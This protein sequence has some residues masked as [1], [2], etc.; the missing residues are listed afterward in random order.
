MHKKLLLHVCCGPCTIVVI[1]ML[2]EMNFEL[3]GIFFNPNIHPLKE[4]LKRRESMNMLAEQANLPMIWVDDQ[5]DLTKWLAMVADNPQYG[6][7]CKSCYHQRLFHV[8]QQAEKLEIP[9]FSSSLLYSKMQLHELIASTGKDIS[10]HASS[11]QF[12]YHDFR[13]RWQE[14]IDKA[15]E[16]DLYRQ[17]YCGCIY[18]E[19][20]RFQ[21]KLKALSKSV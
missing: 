11:T 9:Y 1:D 3:T 18:S 8:M 20:E 2:R 19:S 21:K 17:N 14:G 5:Y 15:K 4:Y 16:D 13:L 6:E 12:F 10:S 7:R